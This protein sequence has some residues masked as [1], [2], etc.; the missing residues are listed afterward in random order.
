MGEVITS[1]REITVF[2]TV[3]VSL[4]KVK[5]TWQTNKCSAPALVL[6]LCLD[7]HW[8][9]RHFPEMILPGSCSG[10]NLDVSF[11]LH[12]LAA[13]MK[14]ALVLVKDTENCTSK[15]FWFCY[16]EL[17]VTVILNRFGSCWYTLNAAAVAARL[18]RG[19]S[20]AE[21]WV[22][23]RSCV[24]VWQETVTT[25]CHIPRPLISFPYFVSHFSLSSFPSSRLSPLKCDSKRFGLASGSENK[26]VNTRIPLSN[27]SVRSVWK[28]SRRG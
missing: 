11:L 28:A 1:E 15:K 16:K 21:C 17:Y 10:Y 5:I 8:S 14:T 23:S 7:M 9:R 3:G 25:G 26:S 18:P 22:S 6:W 20:Q 24:C 19:L 2:Y 27:P 12:A 13:N 4:Q